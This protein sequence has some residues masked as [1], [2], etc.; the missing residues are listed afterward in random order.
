MKKDKINKPPTDIFLHIPKTAGS[1]VFS[2]LRLNYSR[3]TTFLTQP[4]QSNFGLEQLY[5]LSEDKRERLRLVTGHMPFGIH[6]SFRHRVRYFTFLRDPV[7][8][9]ISD[10][11]FVKNQPSSHYLY[12]QANTLSLPEYLEYRASIARDNV[13]ARLL[14]GLWDSVPFSDGNEFLLKRAKQNLKNYFV[15]VGLAERFDES[16][17]LLKRALNLRIIYYTS[18]NV[19]ASRPKVRSI[20]KTTIDVVRYYN[21]LDI[22]LYN[23]GRQL[24]EEQIAAY[25]NALYHDL[26]AFGRRNRLIGGALR[27]FWKTSQGLGHLIT[28]SGIQ[29]KPLLSD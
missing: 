26:E 11:Y 28:K 18:H 19:T 12:H 29:C 2:V 4:E 3:A 25:G 5:N 16:L 7:E 20:P 14:S 9:S 13:Q 6:E 24:F 15:M 21:Q 23:L 17:L 10:Y 8:R 27:I 1:S 22:E